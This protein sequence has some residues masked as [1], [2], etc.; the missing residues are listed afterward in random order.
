MFYK[1][2]DNIKLGCEINFKQAVLI[3]KKKIMRIIRKNL[4][5]LHS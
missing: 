1:D 2:M 5:T 3:K 4:F